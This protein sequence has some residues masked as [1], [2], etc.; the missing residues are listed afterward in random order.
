[1][2]WGNESWNNVLTQVQPLSPLSFL[3]W[4]TGTHRVLL[5]LQMGR[6]VPRGPTGSVY[7][8]V[9]ILVCS[10]RVSSLFIIYLKG[11]W[12]LETVV[13]QDFSLHHFPNCGNF[14]DPLDIRSKQPAESHCPGAV[15]I[16]A[17][18]TGVFQHWSRHFMKCFFF[19]FFFYECVFENIL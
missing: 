10:S 14:S 19:L 3:M 12:G 7:E 1:M 18:H 17:Q 8:H 4:C 13:M 5:K 11:T 2:V 6:G 9:D 15:L 16:T